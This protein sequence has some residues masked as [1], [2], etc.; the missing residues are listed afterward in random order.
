MNGPFKLNF[1]L[2][3]WEIKINIGMFSVCPYI[4]RQS[5]ENLYFCKYSNFRKVLWTLEMH[6][7][8]IKRRLKSIEEI[9]FFITFSSFKFKHFWNSVNSLQ[10][11]KKCVRISK[12]YYFSPFPFEQILYKKNILLFYFVELNW[13]KFSLVSGLVKK[14]ILH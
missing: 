13:V 1:F 5:L 8:I 2:G 7:C 6:L 3:I 12:R 9:L 10:T 14:F 11:L 4:T